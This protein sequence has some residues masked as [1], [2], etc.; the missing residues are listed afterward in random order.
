MYNR[1][2][3]VYEESG[4]YKLRRTGKVLPFEVAKNTTSGSTTIK[5]A[6]QPVKIGTCRSNGPNELELMTEYL[7]EK[8]IEKI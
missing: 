3:L 7:L 2:N 1:P 6:G 4:V 5:Y 8:G